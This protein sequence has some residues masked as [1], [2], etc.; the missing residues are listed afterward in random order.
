MTHALW[1]TL[2]PCLMWLALVGGSL[3]AAHRLLETH[4]EPEALA[5]AERVERE[6]RN[7]D[8]DVRAA[9]REVDSIGW[10]AP[11]VAVA[12]PVPQTLLATVTLAPTERNAR[13]I[14]DAAR[15]AEAW[16]AAEQMRGLQ[17]ANRPSEQAAQAAALSAYAQGLR[18]GEPVAIGAW[19]R[20][21]QNPPPRSVI[22]SRPWFWPYVQVQLSSGVCILHERFGGGRVSREWL[23]L[24]RNDIIP[25]LR[26]LNGR[27][28]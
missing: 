10:A 24:H 6:L 16:A 23:E 4:R 5:F 8:P 3:A 19:L 7:P 1:S 9:L 15:N 13:L 12:E 28:T 2:I 25:A 21:Q 17:N 27:E 20:D 11:A 18:T 22:V 14:A 26:A